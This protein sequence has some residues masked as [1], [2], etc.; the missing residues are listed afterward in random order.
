MDHARSCL[1]VID[2]QDCF[3]AKLDPPERAAVVSR[4]A[5]LVRVAG[6]LDVPVIAMAEDIMRQQSLAP[7]VAD[8]LPSDCVVHDKLVFGLAGQPEILA[9]VEQTR[10]S[11]M[12]LVGLETDVCVAQSALGLLDAGYRVAALEDAIA[13]S[14]SAD[15]ARGIDRMRRAGAIIT[16][17]KGLYY[18]WVRDVATDDRVKAVVGAARP[19]GLAL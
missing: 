6:V 7:E 13:S 17:V 19:P 8:V 1:V 9:A 15:H 14:A 2:V 11:D 18:E 12:I 16:S 10:R 5:W 3:L 4:I